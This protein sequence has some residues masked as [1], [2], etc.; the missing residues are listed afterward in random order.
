V[1][2]DVARAEEPAPEDQPVETEPSVTAS[3]GTLQTK[4]TEVR[5]KADEARAAKLRDEQLR[6]MQGALEGSGAPS[7]TGTA[8]RDAAP[9]QDYVNRLV[10]RIKQNVVFGDPV[11]G[12]PAAEVEV[13]A[14]AT[15]TIVAR[16]LVK[17]S[18]VPEWDEAVLRAIDRTGTLPRQADG[19]VPPVLI[20]AFRPKE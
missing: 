9:S 1:E 13:R 17:S 12:N 10:A 4:L 15:G 2:H 7:S 14:A 3:E 19:R 20:V 11:A 8:E 6:R 16:R 18:G 5:A